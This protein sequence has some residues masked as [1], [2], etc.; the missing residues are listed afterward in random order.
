MLDGVAHNPPELLCLPCTDCFTRPV[1]GVRQET[2]PATVNHWL[3]QVRREHSQ[4]PL[5]AIFLS[6]RKAVE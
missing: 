5:E 1:L 2:A 3:A 4:G 6:A